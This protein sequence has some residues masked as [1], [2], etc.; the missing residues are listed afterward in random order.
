MS[1]KALV[2]LLSLYLYTVLSVLCMVVCQPEMLS[3]PHHIVTPH[4]TTDW[5]QL[6]NLKCLP[7]TSTTALPGSQTGCL[8]NCS[9]PWMYQEDF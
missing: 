8:D 4:C 7:H 5:H 9:F 3:A 1:W 6:D 2:L